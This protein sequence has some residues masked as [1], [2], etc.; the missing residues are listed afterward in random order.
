MDG[1]RRGAYP[2]GMTQEALKE[3][4]VK[5]GRAEAKGSH[6][7][8]PAEVELSLIAVLGQENMLIDRVR[9]V[10]LEPAFVI[11]TT[12]R[13]TYAVAY[14]EVRAVR[15]VQPSSGAGYEG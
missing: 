5:L 6:V 13:E 8:I 10:D 4:L 14:E 3:I 1:E 11:A 9:S 15:V 12:R 7:D 2:P